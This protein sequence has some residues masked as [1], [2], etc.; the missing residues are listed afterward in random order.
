[1]K[2]YREEFEPIVGK[3][4]YEVMESEVMKKIKV[5]TPELYKKFL[6]K[7]FGKWVQIYMD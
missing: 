2:K 3:K 7:E 4:D 5:F 6:E 1:M